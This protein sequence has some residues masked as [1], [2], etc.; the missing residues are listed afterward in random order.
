MHA[1]RGTL[2]NTQDS[3]LRK[4][5]IDLGWGF[6]VWYHLEDDFDSINSVLFSSGLDQ[7]GWGIKEFVP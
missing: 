7:D 4:I 2:G 6:G 3:V 1:V 5:K